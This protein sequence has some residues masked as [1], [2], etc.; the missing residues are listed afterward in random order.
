MR[1]TL[2]LIVFLCLFSFAYS[3]II[4]VDNKIPSIGQYS[5]LQAAHDIANNGD[6]IQLMPSG[7]PYNA[8]SITKSIKIVGCGWQPSS[9]FFIRGT[10]LNGTLTIAS[11]NVDVEGLGGRFSIST[12][13]TLNNII[14]SKCY[15]SD[16]SISENC[17]NIVIKQNRISNSSRTSI[18][19]G[20]NVNIIFCNNIIQ[21]CFQTGYGSSTIFDVLSSN[22]SIINN[23]LIGNS[24]AQALSTNY[25]STPL[26]INTAYGNLNQEYYNGAF[27]QF[28][29]DTYNVFIGIFPNSSDFHLILGSPA[30]DAGNPDPMFND[31]DGSRNDCGAYGGPTPFVDGGIT[32]LPAIYQISGPQVVGHDENWELQIKAKTNRE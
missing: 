15:I 30:I 26:V 20:N 29:P 23:T 19:W 31:L 13:N 17:Y 24:W 22:I 18:T 3:R 1:Y 5:T 16:L 9:N 21:N 4:T 25:S 8:I 27:Q 12:Y 28:M 6:T 7:T 14:V 11:N 2:L 10:D 32:G